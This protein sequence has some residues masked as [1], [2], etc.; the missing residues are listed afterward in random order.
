MTGNITKRFINYIKTRQ[1]K[2][3]PFKFRL[4]VFRQ[5][6]F[7]Q[8]IILSGVIVIVFITLVLYSIY[9][10]IYQPNVTKTTTI[11]I[12]TGSDYQHILIILKEKGLIRDLASFNWVAQRKIY[13]SLVRPGAYKINEGWDNNTLINMLRSG[14]QT[15]VNVTFNNIRYRENLAGRLARYL[16]ADS[17]SFLYYLN[18]DSLA[19]LYGFTHEN[20]TSI[21]IPNTYEFYWTTTPLN[22][23]VRMKREYDLFWNDSRRNKAAMLGLSQP[24]VITLAS[25]IQEETNKNDEKPRI[26]GV[27]LNRLHRGWLLQADPTIKYAMHDFS[28]KRILED[29]LKIDSPYNTY[30]YPGLPPGPIN[31]PDI[32]SIDAVLNSEKHDYMYFCA[33]DDFS[34]YHNF[35]R[36]LH[37]HNINAANYQR[38][39]NKIKIWK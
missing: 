24:Q 15:P 35:A 18:N 6:K 3:K 16:E 7:K 1:F 14:V 19:G 11:Y 33:K 38:A 12:P 37:E 9:N 21:F 32:A 28:V 13:P 4:P 5:F 31:L 26:S 2:F 36:T 22:F 30:K 25:I 27:Y 29:Y 23:I 39:L 34:G 8:V 20:F 17:V 10:K